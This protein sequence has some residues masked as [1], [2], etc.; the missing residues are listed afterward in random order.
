MSDVK[1]IYVKNRSRGRREEDRQLLEESSQQNRIAEV[2]RAILS[3][4]NLKDLLELI[5]EQT[6]RI[7][8]AKRCTVFLYDNKTDELW[9]KVATGITRNEI[10]IPSNLGLAGWVF[11]HQKP[12]IINDAYHDPRFFPGIDKDT[13]FRT[14]N[15]LCVPLINRKHTCTGVIQMLNKTSGN[16]TDKDKE[17]LTSISNYISIALENSRLYEKLKS[18]NNARKKVIEHL[19]HELRTPVA[20]IGTGM[21]TIS[22]DLSDQ[23][24]ENIRKTLAR[25]KRSLNK[26]A[27]IQDIITDILHYRFTEQKR[28]VV[29]IIETVFDLTAEIDKNK[30]VAYKD[31]LD[32]LH[33]RLEY[34]YR[35]DEYE[36]ESIA[37]SDFLHRICDQAFKNMGARRLDILRD[38]SHSLVLNTDRNMLGKV[39]SGLLKNAIEATPDNG[40]IRVSTKC[41]N[42]AIHI[43]IQDW[44]VGITEENQKNIF[45][46]FFHTQETD[47]YTT[48][49]PYAFYAGGTGSDLLRIKVFSERFGFTVSF[50][51]TCCR[52]IPGVKNMCPGKV[53]NC[54]HVKD[55]TGC[56]SSGGSTF[57]LQFPS[58]A[59]QDTP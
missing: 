26:L 59:Y 8:K 47:F 15:V 2:G 16:F 43:E 41:I 50:N 10:R 30:S 48:K 6:V 5:M 32:Y 11:N 39:C 1:T 9:S 44:G 23:N 53:S 57:I 12:L 14:I 3:E 35:I 27:G 13:G 25:C 56:L 45:N 55:V 28:Q 46:G 18:V 52:Y 17:L 24:P 20:I 37:L 49:K 33:Q 4:M 51:S 54:P 19:A 22:R 38:F 34:I 36:Q 31:V 29:R 7:L 58:E 42:D 21:E 40:R